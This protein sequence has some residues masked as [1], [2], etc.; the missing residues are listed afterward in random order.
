MQKALDKIVFSEF[1]DNSQLFKN[2]RTKTNKQKSLCVAR[3]SSPSSVQLGH[4]M[5]TSEYCYQIDIQG[6]EKFQWV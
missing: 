1:W 2:Q 6:K 3:A 4:F 5:P